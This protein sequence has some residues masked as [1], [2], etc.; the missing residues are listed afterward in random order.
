MKQVLMLETTDLGYSPKDPIP[1]WAFRTAADFLIEVERSKM[2]PENIRTLTEEMCN[3]LHKQGS[4]YFDGSPSGKVI[5]SRREEVEVIRNLF[6]LIADL[7]QEGVDLPI[8]LNLQKAGTFAKLKVKPVPVFAQAEPQIIN[9][10]VVNPENLNIMM[11][12][13]QMDLAQLIEEQQ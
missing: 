8:V 3:W 9:G 6:N 5:V 1:S 7:R 13:L 10:D 11:D 4:W 2:S 12:N